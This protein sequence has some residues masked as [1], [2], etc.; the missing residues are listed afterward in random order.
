MRD[1]EASE[2][3]AQIT[4]GDISQDAAVEKL[5]DHT[6]TWANNFVRLRPN[7]GYLKDDIIS[8][9]YI[10]LVQACRRAKAKPVVAAYLRIKYEEHVWDTVGDELS[11]TESQTA[12][13]FDVAVEPSQDVEDL[14]ADLDLTI[15]E[16]RMLQARLEGYTWVEI[17]RDFGIHN[18]KRKIRVLKDKI[19]S[20]P[21]VS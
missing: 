15:D 14:V 21:W 3:L 8:S 17:Q 19:G 11:A 16:K 5:M 20:L 18:T 10:G 13:K 7:L 9:A 6:Q 4:S 1:K 2:I 12:L